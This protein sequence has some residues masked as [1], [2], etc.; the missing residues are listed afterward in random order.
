MTHTFGCSVVPGIVW[1]TEKALQFFLKVIFSSFSCS[2]TAT[3]WVLPFL[4][5]SAKS[6]APIPSFPPLHYCPSTSC[7]ESQVSLVKQ[8]VGFYSES[9]AHS[10][11][12]PD[13]SS[14]S[15]YE[16]RLELA[17]LWFQQCISLDHGTYLVTPQFPHLMFRFCG[18]VHKGPPSRFS[19]NCICSLWP[20]PSIT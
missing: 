17:Y 20:Y 13:P 4:P 15:S 6:L 8:S 5:K 19:I 16:S 18:S 9:F 7:L 11:L 12:P 14:T 1:D 3:P 2:H 10:P